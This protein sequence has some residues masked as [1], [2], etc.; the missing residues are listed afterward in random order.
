MIP[1]FVTGKL[2]DGAVM[3]ERGLL[4]E[5][6]AGKEWVGDRGTE[7]GYHRVLPLM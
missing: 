2:V 6:R 5:V 7:G 4:G 1:R 3:K